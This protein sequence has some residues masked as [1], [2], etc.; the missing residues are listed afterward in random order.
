MMCSLEGNFA[1]K[2]SQA[3]DKRLQYLFIDELGDPGSH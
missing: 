1:V 2:G 3:I